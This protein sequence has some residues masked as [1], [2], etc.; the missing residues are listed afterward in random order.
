VFHPSKLADIQMMSNIC[1]SGYAGTVN[2]E[3]RG[4]E[5]SQASTSTFV[6]PLKEIAALEPSKSP[7]RMVKR[8]LPKNW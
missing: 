8:C 5:E 3:Q 7:C 4:K 2:F 6:H 1:L